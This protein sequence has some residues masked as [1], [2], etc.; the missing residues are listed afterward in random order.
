VPFVSVRT[1][2]ASGVIAVAAVGV[3]VVPAGAGGASQ[4]APAANATSRVEAG[5]ALRPAPAKAS[6]STTFSVPK[7]AC[8]ATGLLGVAPG[9]FIFTGSGSAASLSGATVFVVCQSGSTF[10]QA[11]TIVNGR[12]TALPVS[13]ARGDK[14]VASVS[15]STT[16]VSVTLNDTTRHLSY[17]LTG[18]GNMPA[19][20][21]D[22]IDALDSGSTQLGVP[23]FGSLGFSASTIDGK[24]LVA[25]AARALDRSS[26]THLQIKTGARDATGTRFTETY[27]HS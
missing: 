19:Q 3:S 20:V 6:A 11:E 10:Y 18:T 26:L 4:Y 27:K 21:L 16:K 24:T 7:L 8:P 12:R 2:V 17:T 13:A 5:Y 15:V 23:N 9:A 14:I 25:A 1:A 22:G